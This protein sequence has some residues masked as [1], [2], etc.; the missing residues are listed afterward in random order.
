[1]LPP[2]GANVNL[3]SPSIKFTSFKSFIEP[4]KVFVCVCVFQQINATRLFIKMFQ[5]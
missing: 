5:S 4:E 1:M 2:T 3:I